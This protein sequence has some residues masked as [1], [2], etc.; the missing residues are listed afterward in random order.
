MKIEQGE[1]KKPTVTLESAKPKAAEKVP[2]STEPKKLTVTLESAKPKAAEKVPSS[3]EPKKLT[4]T[5]E[6]AKPKA[7]ENVA[8]STEPG[9][10][11]TE[12]SSAMNGSSKYEEV[13]FPCSKEDCVLKRGP[14][15]ASY[16]AAMR[17]KERHI[18]GLRKRLFPDGH[19]K[20]DTSSKK[21][22]FNSNTDL[23]KAGKEQQ[24]SVPKETKVA[25]PIN[26]NTDLEKA[27][28]EKQPSAPKETKVTTP[29]DSNPDLEKAEKEQQP[30]LPKET[31]V[32]TPKDSN[33]DAGKNVQ[34]E[35]VVKTP[36]DNTDKQ[37]KL[38]RLDLGPLNLIANGSYTV[39]VD[40]KPM[41][42]FITGDD[43]PD[44][45]SQNV[46]GVDDKSKDETSDLS[47]SYKQ[48]DMPKCK[49]Q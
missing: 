28:K 6:S 23:E 8:S 47:A 32:A 15:G 3:T 22:K 33:A 38:D 45:N 12:P 24:P 31:K 36:S 37:Q 26:S 41:K 11:S 16:K 13:Y 2:S 9:P 10:C 39:Y 17:I 14:M 20:S 46:D 4:V 34:K 30:S 48:I 35:T 1:P 44:N 49:L 25:T 27:E 29:I 42:I 18:K 19:K 21:V 40:G 5:P 7:A 43:E